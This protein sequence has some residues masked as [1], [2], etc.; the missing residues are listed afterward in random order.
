MLQVVPQMNHLKRQSKGSKGSYKITKTSIE[1]NFTM[2]NL[3]LVL[4]AVSIITSCSSERETQTASGINLE[5]FKQGDEAD[6]LRNA[7]VVLMNANIRTS[8]GQVI[9]KSQ[10]NDPIIMRYD[11]LLTTEQAGLL[12]EV[13]A[14]VRVGDSVYCEIPAKNFWEKTFE[15]SLPDSI[16]ADEVIQINMGVVSQMTI[17]QYQQEMAAKEREINESRF[18]EER[19]ALDQY[20]A[21]NNIEV[22]SSDTGL[23]YVIE[24]QTEGVYPEEGQMVSVKYKGMLLDGSVFDEGTYT[25]ALGRGSVIKGWDIGMSYFRLGERG[26]VYIPRC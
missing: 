16:A 17:P 12:K 21:D 22:I 23:R 2:K 19:A 7:Y 13:L 24:N 18:A 15:R 3:L 6:L 8:A 20:L 26:V 9:V 1:I 4:L 25:F 5:F 14:S 10:P 11:S